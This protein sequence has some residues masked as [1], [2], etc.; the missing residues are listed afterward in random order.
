VPETWIDEFTAY[1]G[2]DSPASEPRLR[3]PTQADLSASPDQRARTAIAPSVQSTVLPTA[4]PRLPPANPPP[5]QLWDDVKE[6]IGYAFGAMKHIP[7]SWRDT[8]DE[9]FGMGWEAG[10][11][12]IMSR[13]RPGETL[14]QFFDRAH[15]NGV[16]RQIGFRRPPRPGKWASLDSAVWRGYKGST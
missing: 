12:A 16:R 2:Q 15:A 5:S 6:L 10:W 1:S 11:P 14:R 3:K 7:P 8:L 9:E 4:L 13:R